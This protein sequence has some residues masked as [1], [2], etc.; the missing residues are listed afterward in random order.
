MLPT[1]Q[2]TSSTSQ[3]ASSV[4]NVQLVTNALADYTRITGINLSGNP[5]IAGLEQPH[6]SEVILQLFQE[7]GKAIKG[8]RDG[9]RRLIS[10]LRPVVNMIQAFSGI[11]GEA[12]SLVSHKDDLISLLYRLR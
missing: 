3:I 6:S 7:R 5:F 12:D 9:D 1:G 10:C 11:L 2:A 4:S 8:Y